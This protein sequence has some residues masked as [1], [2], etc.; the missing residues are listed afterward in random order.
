[1]NIK[2]L[3]ML[4]STSFVLLLSAC[5]NQHTEETGDYEEEL[6]EDLQHEQDFW[7]DEEK[8]GTRTNPLSS[9]DTA[10]LMVSSYNLEE[11]DGFENDGTTN[12]KASLRINEVIRGEEAMNYLYENDEFSEEP[13]DS[14]IEWAVIN[15]TFKLEDFED[16]N[17]SLYI[18]DNDFQ[19]FKIDGSPMDYSSR[20]YI[21]DGFGNHEI[22]SGGT[23]EGD[24]AIAVPK[25]ESFLLNYS[26]YHSGQEVWFEIK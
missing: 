21:D 17:K 26:D 24:F 7:Q 9:S 16:D 13:E 8:T 10:E 20:P 6:E 23:S 19:V 25:N 11:D 5:G 4:T 15:V 2:N 18:S 12:G 1:M 3:F 14:S 22:F